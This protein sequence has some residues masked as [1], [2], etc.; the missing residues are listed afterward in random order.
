MRGHAQQPCLC[1]MREMVMFATGHVLECYRYSQRRAG[2]SIHGRISFKV[3][4][5]CF[6]AYNACENGF[7]ALVFALLYRLE[8]QLLILWDGHLLI[9]QQLVAGLIVWLEGKALRKCRVHRIN[10]DI[11]Y[12]KLALAFPF[13]FT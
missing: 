10:V 3:C 7:P 9:H 5:Q 6:R 2:R 13:P 4:H 12:V 8:E 1:R 11:Y